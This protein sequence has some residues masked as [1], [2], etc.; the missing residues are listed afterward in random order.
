MKATTLQ[1]YITL[2]W[3]IQTKQFPWDILQT[4][5]MKK[6]LAGVMYIC[7]NKAQEE[8]QGVFPCCVWGNQTL[9]TLFVN[10]IAQLC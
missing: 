7:I 8:Q 1:T 5:Q 4:Q 2:F 9:A 3:T 6:Q 10:K